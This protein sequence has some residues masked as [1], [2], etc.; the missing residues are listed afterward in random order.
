MAFTLK[1]AQPVGYDLVAEDGRIAR[2]RTDMDYPELA[3]DLGMQVCCAESYGSDDCEH[4]SV[5]QHIYNAIQFLDGLLDEEF[6][7]DEYPAI[8]YYFVDGGTL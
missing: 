8:E 4:A 6:E 2:I 3:R 1:A 5:D 7:G